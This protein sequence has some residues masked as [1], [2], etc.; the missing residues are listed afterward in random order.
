[1]GQN[2]GYGAHHGISKGKFVGVMVSM[3]TEDSNL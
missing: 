3:Y 2:H 1:M